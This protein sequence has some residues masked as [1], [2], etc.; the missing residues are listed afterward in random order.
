MEAMRKGDGGGHDGMR[1]QFGAGGGPLG[2][3]QS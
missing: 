1:G 2:T 3:L